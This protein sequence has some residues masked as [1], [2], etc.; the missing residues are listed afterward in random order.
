MKFDKIIQQSAF[1]MFRDWSKVASERYPNMDFTIIDET[2]L[3]N[4]TK[5]SVGKALRSLFS[6]EYDEKRQNQEWCIGFV[7]GFI[8]GCLS[9][10]W[11][12]EYYQ[13]QT[14]N[15]RNM[16]AVKSV[17]EFFKI[18]S[19]LKW[20]LDAI[21]K[22]FFKS[23]NL[24]NLEFKTKIDVDFFKKYSI[25]TTYNAKIVEQIFD[26]LS[27]MFAKNMINETSFSL[28]EKEY[29]SDEEVQFFI[30]NK[31]IIFHF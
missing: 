27:T 28:P 6:S 17:L 16:I 19:D 13:K 14:N 1:D 7:K 2:E 21:Y 15:Y 3:V 9:V 20:R 8:E 25:S 24:D 22:E 4:D 18:D 11:F 23:C 31:D 29:F 26:N 30:E 10:K 12:H 5:E